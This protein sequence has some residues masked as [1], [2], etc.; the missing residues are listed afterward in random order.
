DELFAAGREKQPIGPTVLRIVP[1]LEQAMLDEP[2]EQPHQRDR[3]QLQYVG[4][5]DLRQ[6]LLLA[7][8]KQHDPLRARVAAC[9]GA[10]VDKVAQQPR[11][12][13]ELCNQLAFQIDRHARGRLLKVAKCLGFSSH[14]VFAH[15]VHAYYMMGTLGTDLKTHYSFSL[16]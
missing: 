15:K 6:T 8:A 7:Q 1:A 9:L 12:L 5:V 16:S 11:S 4:E 3:L 14:S 2:V 10:V 13:Y